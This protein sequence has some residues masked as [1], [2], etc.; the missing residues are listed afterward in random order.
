MPIIEDFVETVNLPDVSFDYLFKHI[1]L[2]SSK[3]V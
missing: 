3:V 1:P 2:G